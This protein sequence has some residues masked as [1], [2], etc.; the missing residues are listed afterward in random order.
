GGG[1][2]PLRRRLEAAVRNKWSVA[3]RPA[4]LAGQLA[5]RTRTAAL[6]ALNELGLNA[7]IANDG[8]ACALNRVR[9]FAIVG[10]SATGCTH[11]DYGRRYQRS[12]RTF[13]HRLSCSLDETRWAADPLCVATPRQPHFSGGADLMLLGLPRRASGF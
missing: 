1:F 7:A 12:R 9:R 4:E 5:N 3:A 10:R 13:Q 11:R 6:N 2:Q 8:N